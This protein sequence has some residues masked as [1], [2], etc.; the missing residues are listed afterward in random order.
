MNESDKRQLDLMLQKIHIYDAGRLDLAELI[1]D[2]QALLDALTSDELE[3]KNI[4]KTYWWDLEEV[5]SV[6]V[7]EEREL[8]S[9]DQKI[10][11]EAVE[12]FKKLI[13]SKII[14]FNTNL[15]REIG[16]KLTDELNK[17]Y[18]TK[19]ITFWAS[20]L[21][22][23]PDNNYPK[24]INDILEFIFLMDAAP[25]YALSEKE[26]KSLSEMLINGEENPILQIKDMTSKK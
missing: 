9:D 15:K 17:G 25:Q 22:F 19:R 24:E 16:E 18:D 20:N 10:I 14:D 7:C 3:W 6:A 4:F 13:K 23:S 2:L 8:D 5:H 1:N 21:Y 12:N 26:L 11:R